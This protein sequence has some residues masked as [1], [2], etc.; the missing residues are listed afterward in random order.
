MFITIGEFGLRT[1]EATDLIWLRD[2]RN[3]KST[4]ENLE[5]VFP[6]NISIQKTWLDLG[7]GL[8]FP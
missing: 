2:L 6:L 4:W 8:E 3:D 1:I 7:R 5:H